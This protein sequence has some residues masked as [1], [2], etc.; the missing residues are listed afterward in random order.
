L[1]THNELV[2]TTMTATTST[3]STAAERREHLL[4]VAMLEFAQRGYEGGSTERI[5]RAAGIS[6]PYV[7]RLFGS[8]LQLFLAVIERCF[9]DTHDM[10]RTAAS[11]RQGEDVLEAIGEAY[12][13]M[14]TSRPERL[15]CQLVGYA[16]CDEE[17][18]REAM[19]RGYG[20]LVEFVEQ[21]SGATP[22]RI[23]TFFAKGM[24]LNVMTAMRLPFESAPWGDRLIAGCMHRPEAE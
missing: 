16:A 24:L 13:E 12:A 18:V 8:K 20:G 9:A 5:A 3:R 1:T 14:I 19:R 10:F 2:D 22:D 15:Q 6:Q 4:E 17:A 21:A 7:F 23:A 11:G